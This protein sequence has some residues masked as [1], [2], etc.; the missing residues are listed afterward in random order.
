M[1]KGLRLL[2]LLLSTSAFGQYPY[3]YL[4]E[5]VHYEAEGFPTVEF[6]SLSPLLSSDN[7]SSQA[8]IKAEYLGYAGFN[9]YNYHQLDAAQKAKLLKQA[10]FANDDCLYLYD[11][12]RNEHYQFEVQDLKASAFLSF[13]TN[14]R[15]QPYP[16]YYYHIGLEVPIEKLNADREKYALTLGRIGDS[17]PFVK[18]AIQEMEFEIDSC[19]KYASIDTIEIAID[20]SCTCYRYQ[21]DD[22]SMAVI[23]HG[24]G[25]YPQQRDILIS[26]PKNGKL[27]N[28]RNYHSSEGTHLSALNVAGRNYNSQQFTGRLLKDQDLILYGFIDLS[29]GCAPLFFVNDPAHRLGILCD[30]R[31]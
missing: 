30:N 10:G 22:F 26:D 17:N 21:N 19:S 11:L 16:E 7:D 9:N 12:A 25:F 13:Y 8:I 1:S 27:V 14:E 31:H 5:M 24:Q 3:D 15:D 23:D 20:S 4:F 29:F 18:Q 28:H 6:I 2:F